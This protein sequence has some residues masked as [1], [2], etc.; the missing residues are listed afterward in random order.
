MRK[1]YLFGKF[2]HSWVSHYELWSLH[3]VKEKKFSSARSLF[4][5]EG[6]N[7]VKLWE[8]V[9]IFQRCIWGI[10][11]ELL[12][13]FVA[14]REVT[15]FFCTITTEQYHSLHRLVE[16]RL[17]WVLSAKVMFL[18]DNFRRENCT[19]VARSQFLGRNP[20]L[21]YQPKP[22]VIELTSYIIPNWL[23]FV[24]HWPN[25]TELLRL[26]SPKYWFVINVTV[27]Y[28]SLLW[29]SCIM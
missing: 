26:L 29:L 9:I 24:D 16:I 1:K 3:P 7:L 23:T 14:A 4:R 5:K 13:D 28:W 12:D 20:S 19:E 11:N 6:K 21:L 27:C 15:F 10:S 25:V 2:Q 22:E 18:V 8:E 17:L